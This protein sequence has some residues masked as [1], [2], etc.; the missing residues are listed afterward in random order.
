MLEVWSI[1]PVHDLPEDGLVYT[2]EATRHANLTD[3]RISGTFVLDF[4]FR[5][6]LVDIHMDIEVD[7]GSLTAP[8]LASAPLTEVDLVAKGHILVD[9]QCQ[10]V[11][12]RDGDFSIGELRTKVSGTT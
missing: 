2:E 3:A 11:W 6:G 5:L 10:C 1:R 4:A 7:D 12:V 9:T 8:V